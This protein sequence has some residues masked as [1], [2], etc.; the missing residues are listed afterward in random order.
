MNYLAAGHAN[1]LK[2]QGGGVGSE[3]PC[4]LSRGKV[5]EAYDT[6]VKGCL[7]G[8]LTKEPLSMKSSFSLQQR[9]FVICFLATSV[10]KFSRTQRASYLFS[11]LLNS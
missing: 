5:A 4:S 8:K 10:S 7:E 9:K 1:P 2:W 3:H 11:N 6:Q